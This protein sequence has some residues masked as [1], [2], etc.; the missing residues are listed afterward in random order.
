MISRL[1]RLLSFSLCALPISLFAQGLEPAVQAKV[2]TQITQVV[3]LAA[4]PAVVQAVR[5][6]NAALPADY[7][8]MTQE[9]WKA[10]PILEPFVRSFTR[11]PAAAVIKAKKTEFVTEAFL[12]DAAGLK[13]AF[14]AKTSNWSHKGKAKHDKPLAGETWQGPVEVDESTGQQQIQVA[15]PVLD[16]GKPIGSLIVGLSL[17][18][19]SS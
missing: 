16:G 3:A 18:K 17:T 19:L 13:V 1:L 2:N 10:L 5:D 14:L 9:K 6:Q 7:A 4:D 8:A 12:S 15:V 11:N